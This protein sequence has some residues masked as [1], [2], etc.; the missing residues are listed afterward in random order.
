M[1]TEKIIEII[2]T[3]YDCDFI[4]RFYSYYFDSFDPE[5]VLSPKKFKYLMDKYEISKK[6]LVSK[7][8]NISNS[9]HS[10]D[11]QGLLDF[12]VRKQIDKIG[13]SEKKNKN[14]KS[15]SYV[16]NPGTL[17]KKALLE[18]FRNA[19][20]IPAPPLVSMQDALT[21]SRGSTIVQFLQEKRIIDDDIL[22]FENIE[23]L[24]E[25]LRNL[26]E[27]ELCEL[28]NLLQSNSSVGIDD[29]SDYLD[30]FFDETPLENLLLLKK[31]LQIDG[32][33]KEDIQ[34]I[35]T[36]FVNLEY[37]NEYS[38]INLDK[39]QCALRKRRKIKYIPDSANEISMTLFPNPSS[40]IDEHTLRYCDIPDLIKDFLI[41]NKIIKNFDDNTDT[42][43]DNT[44]TFDY[45]YIYHTFYYMNKSI[46]DIIRLTFRSF[47]K[48]SGKSV[49]NYFQKFG[50]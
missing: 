16:R 46:W 11:R 36:L 26:S 37:L 45:D 33:G 5:D 10:E 14:G 1:N 3:F 12:Q 22:A 13:K 35:C 15:Y 25:S 20:P 31:I 48:P 2:C 39:I 21:L 41:K 44:D 40:N 6:D 43:D 24:E 8:E 50:I 34:S 29:E 19:L 7:G 49:I 18:L 17:H 47:S 27:P 23:K 30:Y 32:L 4:N 9:E 28:L 42:S 38:E